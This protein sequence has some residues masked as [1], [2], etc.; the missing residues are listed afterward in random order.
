M[1]REGK[2]TLALVISKFWVS[3]CVFGCKTIELLV[4]ALWSKMW[5]QNQNFS[6]SRMNSSLLWNV[7]IY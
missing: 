2:E 4:S 6:I 1:L 5:N 7:D 3:K